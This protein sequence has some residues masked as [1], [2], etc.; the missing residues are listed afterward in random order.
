MLKN[1]TP[2]GLFFMN[3]P[4]WVQPNSLHADSSLVGA[5][6]AA[7]QLNSS[8]CVRFLAK[9]GSFPSKAFPSIYPLITSVLTNSK[10]RIL[11]AKRTHKRW[12]STSQVRPPP[13]C[14]CVLSTSH[15]GLTTLQA[16]VSSF[17]PT[18]A[19]SVFLH[20]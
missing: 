18:D 19:G 11:P 20:A 15:W 2:I 7:V 5:L 4:F 14:V 3:T 13:L 12:L 16:S 1:K 10:T 9:A 8:P 6:L 17:D